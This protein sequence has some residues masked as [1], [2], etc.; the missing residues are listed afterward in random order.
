MSRIEPCIL[1]NMCMVRNG[2]QVLVQD[3]KDPGWPGYTFPGGH[4]EPG[5]S[6][7]RSVIREVYEETGLTIEAPRLCGVKQWTAEDGGYRYL[8]FLFRAERFTGELRSSDEGEVC[9]LPLAELQSRPMPSGFP[10][11]LPLFLREELSEACYFLRD[12]QWCCE[13]L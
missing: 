11:T 10:E 4:V 1:T 7:V 13:T 2:D 6:L 12:G 8:V 5:E 3:R 9:W